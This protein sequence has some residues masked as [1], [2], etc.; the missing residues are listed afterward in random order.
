MAIKTALEY[1][2][3]DMNNLKLV[4]ATLIAP[5]VTPVMYFVG[6][7]LFGNPSPDGLKDTFTVFMFIAAFSLPVSYAGT[8]IIGLPVL[9]LLQRKNRLT[10]VNLAIAGFVTGGFLFI[11]IVL[12]FFGFDHDFLTKQTTALYFLA[13]G[14]MGVGVALAFSQVSGITSYL[15]R[16]L[17]Y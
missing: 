8:I 11:D 5:L 9:K 17:R 2:W 16:N 14:V 7:Y 13:G 3:I 4:K 6:I 1:P 12:L 10:A 15:N